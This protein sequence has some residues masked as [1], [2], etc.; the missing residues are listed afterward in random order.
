MSYTRLVTECVIISHERFR[1]ECQVVHFKIDNGPG[2]VLLAII[3]ERNPD[4][5]QWEMGQ[6]ELFLTPVCAGHCPGC[7]HVPFTV[8]YKNSQSIHPPSRY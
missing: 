7:V 2:E 5:E 4:V 3:V 1:G 8:R 6:N